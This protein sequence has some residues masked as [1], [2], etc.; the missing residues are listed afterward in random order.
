MK[1]A[2]AFST[3]SVPFQGTINATKVMEMEPKYKLLKK[4]ENMKSL[5]KT[6]LAKAGEGTGLTKMQQQKQRGQV[7][8]R[9]SGMHADIEKETFHCG[10]CLFCALANQN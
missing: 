9:A 7:Q 6:K 8:E 10:P 5:M 1:L 2:S 3:L 4:T